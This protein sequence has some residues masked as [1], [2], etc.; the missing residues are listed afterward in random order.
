M[1]K[2]HLG[3]GTRQIKDFINIDVRPEVN[4][5][6]VDDILKLE[7]I[8]NNSVDLIYICH[9]LEHVSKRDSY[10][11]LQRFHQVLK[12]DG[13]LR[14]AVPDIEAAIKHF[15]KHQNLAAIRTIFWGSQQLDNEY[16]FHKNGWT[17]WT[18]KDDLHLVGF[19]NIKRYDWRV[20]SHHF[21]DDY[22]QS[23]LPHFDKENG[24][25]MSLN[26]EATK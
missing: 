24:Q 13:I 18:L 4:P 6:I 19:H 20:T 16:D 12:T 21:H 11:A 9:C 23:Y 5:D 22:S 1:M 2:L 26:V 8:E 14:I 17:F 7:K 25:L 15:A 3:C 10:K